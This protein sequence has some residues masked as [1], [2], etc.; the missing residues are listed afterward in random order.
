[1]ITR[2]SHRQ[3]RAIVTSAA[4]FVGHRVGRCPF[5][6]V[7][8]IGNFELALRTDDPKAEDVVNE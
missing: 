6:S 4:G 3:T 2:R 8:L 7:I 1:M 5:A